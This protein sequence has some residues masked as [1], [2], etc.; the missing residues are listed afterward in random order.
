VITI[1]NVA[2]NFN[3][4]IAHTVSVDITHSANSLICILFW[5]SSPYKNFVSVTIGSD[6]LTPL[7][8]GTQAEFCYSFRPSA[9]TE[10]VTGTIDASQIVG[11][12]AVELINTVDSEP[13]F[14]SYNYNQ[15]NS[16][17]ASVTISPMDDPVF[18][19]EFVAD[20]VGMD[21]IVLQSG[22]TYVTGTTS[23]LSTVLQYVRSNV[24]PL[25]NQ[26][27]AIVTWVDVAVNVLD[28]SSRSNRHL[29]IDITTQTGF[30]SK[31]MQL[32]LPDINYLDR[33]SN[34][35]VG[36]ILGILNR[37]IYAN[38]S[39]PAYADSLIQLATVRLVTDNINRQI[40]ILP[41][42]P[43]EDRDI[44]LSIP[45]YGD[46]QILSNL[47]I[48]Y[49]LKDIPIYMPI[50]Q[51]I[52]NVD[53]QVV[54]NPQ[55]GFIGFLFSYGDRSIY[56]NQLSPYYADRQMLID[57]S[58][59]K[60][61]QIIEIISLLGYSNSQI[62]ELISIIANKDRQLYIDPRYLGMSNRQIVEYIAALSDRRIYSNLNKLGYVDRLMYMAV[63]GGIDRQILEQIKQTAYS[64]RQIYEMIMYARDRQISSRIINEIGVN[65][66]IVGSIGPRLGM[67]NRQISELIVLPNYENRSIYMK[68][69]LINFADRV[70][71]LLRK[72]KVESETETQ[73]STS[74]TQES[75]T[76]GSSIKTSGD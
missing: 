40:V 6:T 22:Q 61:R 46:R 23:L 27:A 12:W 9:G 21:S 10:T 67:G 59:A 37:Q 35:N 16:S 52:Q 72:Y 8:S 54:L 28:K 24:S 29:S 31:Q 11:I 30:S 51:L 2:L 58:A 70:L 71:F 76:T 63:S 7:M 41:Y 65:R 1:G 75:E 68:P 44:H 43:T 20:N 73:G 3:D 42:S 60:D 26:I 14:S 39:A 38:I 55:E 50:S 66:Q 49:G 56:L 18:T 15:Q 17:W 74:V 47:V 62:S 57:L 33:M 25:I 36:S 32:K 69:A 48:L 45:L 13:F 64:N 53:R 5:Q 19:L 34:L 4:G